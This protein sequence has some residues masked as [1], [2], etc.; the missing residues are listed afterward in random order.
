MFDSDPFSAPP[1]A[2]LDP[3]TPSEQERASRQ[4]YRPVWLTTRAGIEFLDVF[5]GD[6]PLTGQSEHKLLFL[7]ERAQNG[8]W[9]LGVCSSRTVEGGE[10][11]AE[12][13][14]HDRAKAQA[15]ER[16]QHWSVD[17]GGNA[18]WRFSPP[19]PGQISLIEKIGLDLDMIKTKG[20]ASDVLNIHFA[21]K[22]LDPIFGL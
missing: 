20:D 6:N 12:E 17:A 19:S 14:D 7:V 18:A 3:F 2:D 22:T 4:G 21:S 1:G 16:A 11:L 9:K 15:E 10:W 13:I 5:T 8:T